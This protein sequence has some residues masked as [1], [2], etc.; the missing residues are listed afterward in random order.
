M[1]FV[2]KIADL[3]KLPELKNKDSIKTTELHMLMLDRI[4]T[5]M[6]DT[7]FI[8]RIMKTKNLI[9][10]RQKITHLNQPEIKKFL[11]DSIW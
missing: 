10:Q 4:T 7:Y 1:V 11:R 8:L 9:S 6:T 3:L 5:N 2:D